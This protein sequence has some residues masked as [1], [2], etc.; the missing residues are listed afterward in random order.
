ML[1]ATFFFC[2]G[3][4]IPKLCDKSGQ[5]IACFASQEEELLPHFVEPRTVDA[6]LPLAAIVELCLGLNGTSFVGH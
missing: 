1:I 3:F 6:P 4:L 5:V 2:Q